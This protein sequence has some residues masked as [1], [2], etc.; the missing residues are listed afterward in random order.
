[1]RVTYINHRVNNDQHEVETLGAFA[2]RAEAGEKLEVLQ[3]AVVEPTNLY[4]STR[5]TD[6]YYFRRGPRLLNRS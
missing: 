2:T 1:M 3:L 5:A 6:E 4:L